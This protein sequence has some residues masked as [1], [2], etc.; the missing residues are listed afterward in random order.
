[1][2]K[3]STGVHSLA[4]G[5]PDAL[6][7]VGNEALLS[8]LLRD[9]RENRLSHAYIIEGPKGSGKHTIARRLCAA[10]ACENRPG[11]TRLRAD[12]DQMGFF[13][14]L[15]PAAPRVIP[16]DAP[17]PCGQCLP[18]RKLLDGSCPDVRVISRED[19]ATLG[20]DQV[21][22]LRQDVLIPPNDLDTKIY[23]I[24]D[25]ETMT[26][27]AQ[28]A[29]LLT[30]EEPP[31]YVLFLLLCDGAESLL[32][33]IRSRAPIL[34]TR[35]LPDADV[36][37]YLLSHRRTLPE[38]EMQAVLLRAGGSI[39]QAMTLSD[40]KAVKPILKLRE[41]CGAFLTASADRRPDGI[42]SAVNQFGT[43]RDAVTDA[44][45]ETSLALRDLLL[46]KSSE[47]LRLCWFTDREA[48]LAL[49]DRFTSRKLL[50]M[51]D[52]LNQAL[53][54]LEGNGNVRLVLTGMCINAGL[55]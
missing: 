18:C 2:A 25:A 28:N 45:K 15:A 46:L 6:R 33:T 55:L 31:S 34:R 5:E 7:V 44:L 48:A 23:V 24:E 14:A 51:T 17:L 50:C 4:S 10:I 16:A 41:L 9:V 35:H 22:F 36:R 3:E 47:T 29:L 12:E 42:L 39:G 43:K 54:E 27:Q 19:K 1:M 13:D 32:E 52:A 49:S 8:K 53:D 11:Q 30:L 26:V 21:R 38:S 37:A 20:V 40:A